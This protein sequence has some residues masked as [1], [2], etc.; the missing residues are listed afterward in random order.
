MNS[1]L[2][3]PGPHC[4]QRP[5][6]RKL[7]PFVVC[8][9]AATLI[10][11]ISNGQKT[12]DFNSACQ[13]AYHAII[14]LRLDKGQFLLSQ[15]KR[16]HPDN[17]IPYLLDN[18]IDF[19]VLYFNEDPNEFDKRKEN[20]E[21]RLRII[22][23]GP[24]TSPFYFFS[25][26]V[27]HFQWAAV[28]IKFGHNWDAGWEFRRSFL[29][30]KENRRLF[31]AFKANDMLGGTMEVA[32][33]TIPEG[34]HWL[35][36]LLGISG[37]IEAGMDALSQ[38]IGQEDSLSVLFHDEAIFYYLYL[39]FYIQ[40][41]K[42]QVFDYIS[43]HN[44]DTRNNHL[45]AYLA[46]NLAIN[47]QKSAFAEEILRQLNHDDGYLKMPAWDYE[48]GTAR[49]NHLQQDANI[50]LEKFLAQFKGN[51]YLKEVLLKLSWYYFLND[52]QARANEYRKWVIQKGN[53]D[54][55]A[56]KQ[57][58]DEAKKG[59]W[60]NPVLLK[61]RLLDDGGYFKEAMQVLELTNPND[62][63]S[64]EAKLEWIYRKGRIYDDMGK[65]D[66][67]IA[68]Y[69]QAIENGAQSKAYY[70]ARAALQIGFIYEKRSNCRKATQYFEKCLS[71]KEHEYKNSL[72]QKAKAGLLRCRRSG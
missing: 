63:R 21:G 35:S 64:P 33:G 13:E 2:S 46:A 37:T 22:S 62:L 53:T 26:A 39:R 67:A 7:M 23:S 51:F 36:N 12:F 72:D 55:E 69:S 20:L 8:L 59:G 24:E 68:A 11:S 6:S 31:P 28:K 41:Q 16:R 66:E 9:F 45:F 5:N 14:E 44:L 29:Q 4:E 58:L 43:A 27:L 15:E 49:M 32:A 57:A 42:S 19:F 30:I 61:S 18:Y 47:A 1:I 71:M 17:L 56:D 3:V 38:F 40:N 70:A 10:S 54:T 50:W 25:K 60:P 65:E 34:Y 48:M 52:D